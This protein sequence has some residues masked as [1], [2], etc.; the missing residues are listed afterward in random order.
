MRRTK[1]TLKK[2]GELQMNEEI[3][4]YLKENLKIFADYEDYPGH[5]GNK[6]VITLTL[7]REK[8]SEAKIFIR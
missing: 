1:N 7:G 4:K 3:Q 6:L 5:M 2:L 8:I